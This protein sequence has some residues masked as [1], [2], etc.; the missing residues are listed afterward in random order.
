MVR[1]FVGFARNIF[2]I[3][4]FWV[5]ITSYCFSVCGNVRL[6]TFFILRFSNFARF[7][8]SRISIILLVR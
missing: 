8:S 3:A 2:F 6:S 7:S 1:M 5:S 4:L